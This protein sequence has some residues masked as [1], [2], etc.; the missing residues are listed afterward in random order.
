MATQ[1]DVQQL[2]QGLV[3][4]SV[5]NGNPNTIYNAA[6]PSMNAQGQWSQAGM[7]QAA[8]LA[9]LQLPALASGGGGGV[10]VWAPPTTAGNTAVRDLLAS[11]PDVSN[12]VRPPT[13]AVPAV[14]TTPTNTGI[15]RPSP[16]NFPQPVGPVGHERGTPFMGNTG[17]GGAGGRGYGG[18]SSAGFS[19]R[20][21]GTGNRSEF[22]NWVTNKIGMDDTGS[23]DW[24]QM[25]DA[26]S[27]PFI[28]GDLWKSNINKFDSFAA[29]KGMLDKLGLPDSLLAGLAKKGIFGDK[30]HDWAWGSE[31]LKDWNRDWA[32][33]RQDIK[34]HI[35]PEVK[36]PNVINLQPPASST[37]KEGVVSV[38]PISVVGG[39][40]GGGFGGGYSV[41][42]N[43]G[44]VFGGAGGASTGSWL[45]GGS[46]S[47]F[48][49]SNTGFGSIGGSGIFGGGGSGGFGGFGGSGGGGSG[50][51]DGLIHHE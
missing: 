50:S 5:N 45:S 38:G 21:P 8:T 4:G 47:M 22:I 9:A 11:L 37:P 44:G 25:L 26:I 36:V 30:V 16:V 42:N 14:P 32:D 27:E 43:F 24:Q 39:G 40:G 2:I 17:T 7:P 15:G 12:W 35:T 19:G 3:P 20:G 23:M 31:I 48:G 6:A 28:Q 10:P 33:W 49:S 29:V 34:Q 1:T 41:G 13:P 46:G 51:L 18:S